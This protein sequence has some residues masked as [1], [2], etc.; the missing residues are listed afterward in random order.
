MEEPIANSSMLVLPSSTVPA[1]LSRATTVASYGGRQPSRI[2]E[3]QVVGTP[4]VT[5]TSLSATGT[6]ASGPAAPAGVDSAARGQ[7]GLGVDVQEGAAAAVLGGDP[8]EV[9]AGDLDRRRPRRRR[10]PGE[11]GGVE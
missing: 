2:F 10:A 6:P 1:A 5:T 8:V 3:P 9:G 11:L 4:S 7:R